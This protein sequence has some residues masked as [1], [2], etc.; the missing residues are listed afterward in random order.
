MVS[1]WSRS[2]HCGW[3]QRALAVAAAPCPWL[4]AVVCEAV[5]DG[6][7][8]SAAVEE[9]NAADEVFALGVCWVAG[10][11]EVERLLRARLHRCQA[12]G[13][14]G[15]GAVDL[16]SAGEGLSL[17]LVERHVCLLPCELLGRRQHAHDVLS[18]RVGLPVVGCCGPCSWVGCLALH[19][20]ECR[21]TRALVW[22]PVRTWCSS[23]PT[24]AAAGSWLGRGMCLARWL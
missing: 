10:E 20:C 11:E 9:P 23:L 5:A 22:L 18:R 6:G 2:A 24:L 17:L 3:G 8:S 13:D 19:R 21:H 1:V 12:V 4:T 7:R 14:G 15:G 16:L